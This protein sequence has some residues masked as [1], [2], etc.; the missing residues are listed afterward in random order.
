FLS[1][2]RSRTAPTSRCRTG[3]RGPAGGRPS[4]ELV[5]PD[6]RFLVGSSSAGAA[7]RRN[8]A[9]LSSDVHGD[10]DVAVEVEVLRRL[11]AGGGGGDL[12]AGVDVRQQIDPRRDREVDGGL[13]LRHRREVGDLLLR[14]RRAGR[15]DEDVD[16]VDEVEVARR[17]RVRRGGERL[18]QNAAERVALDRLLRQILIDVEGDQPASADRGHEPYG[19]R[20]GEN[21]R[22]THL[23]VLVP[24][25][26]ASR[27]RGLTWFADWSLLRT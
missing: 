13:A 5:R 25:R 16:L 19:R 21:L 20:G 9:Q 12:G 6:G 17:H 22:V 8:I 23:H 10:G 15:V 14:Q 7:R 26:A 27:D 18:R 24:V 2:D 11:A 3:R 1:L 4:T